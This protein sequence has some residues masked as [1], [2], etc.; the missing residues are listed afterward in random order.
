MTEDK[1]L[2]RAASYSLL[3]MVCVIAF[4]IGI[5]PPAESIS[6]A[7]EITPVLSPT[8]LIEKEIEAKPTALPLIDV[9]FDRYHYLPYEISE[10][11]KKTLGDNFIVIEKPTDLASGYSITLEDLS[12]DRRIIITIQGVAT[13]TIAIQK[14]HRF[15]G[16][17]YHMDLPILT[18]MT[19]NEGQTGVDPL[20]SIAVMHSAPNENGYKTATIT[21]DLIKTYAYTIH[22]DEHYF[23]IRLARP[24]DVYDKIVVL[25][26]GHGGID[27]GTYSKGYEYLEKM[28]NLDMVLRLSAYL[29]EDPSIK[30]YTTR[31][32]DRRLTLN[33]RVNLANDVEADFFLSI[34]CN[35]NLSKKISGTEVLYN[36]KQ[37]DWNGMNSKLF[38]R[39]CLDELV[40]AIDLKDRGIVP[41]S[42][43]VHIIG[44]AQVPVALV[45][46]A[47]MSN[48]SDLNFLK[49]EENRQLAAEGIYNGIMRAFEEKAS[50]NEEREEYE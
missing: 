45:E 11:M 26:A 32:T 38:A 29:D 9:T 2:K 47:F 49:K 18:E 37:N 21:M 15:F 22:E 44:E 12:V 31:T 10:E 34:H 25:D 35:S 39:I 16:D 6:Y 30:V 14:I 1:L 13:D 46:V 36:D 7:G 20:T 3:L 19:G 41:R 42:H 33:Q 8:P 40:K 28:M 50:M 48:S 43:D 24:K 5:H 4:S 27:S 17:D 23:Y